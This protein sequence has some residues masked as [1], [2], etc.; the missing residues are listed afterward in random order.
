MPENIEISQLDLRYEGFRMKNPALERKLLAALQLDGVREPLC[1]ADSGDAHILLDGFKRL[2][3][4]RSLGIHTVPYAALAQDQAAAIVR[5]LRG[6]QSQSLTILEQARFVDEL[7]HLCQMSLGEIAQHLSRCKSWVSMRLGLFAELP[8]A[9]CEKLFAGQFPARS[10]LYTIRPFTR[11]NREVS[12]SVAQFVLAL[13]G[14]GL[15]VREIAFLFRQC[16]DGSPAWREQILAGRIELPLRHYRES[17]NPSAGCASAERQV[18][19]DLELL[20]HLMQTLAARD[21]SHLPSADFQVQ[22]SLLAA[23]ILKQA[24]TFV[25]KV[26]EIHAQRAHP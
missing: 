10:Y 5:I 3:C 19:K 11:V 8:E 22:A 17:Q 25:K 14:R 7:H 24:P 20:G 18:L 16:F 9:V 6:H 21:K 23:A 26:R 15:S 4:A 12:K 2:R 1:G 13:S